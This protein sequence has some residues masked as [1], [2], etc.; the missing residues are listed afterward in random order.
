M[1]R[2]SLGKGCR[3]RLCSG[4]VQAAVRAVFKGELHVGPEISICHG[5][6]P[7]L[8]PQL[9]KPQPYGRVNGTACAWSSSCKTQL[10][11]LGQFLRCIQHFHRASA[12]PVTLGE[13]LQEARLCMPRDHWPC[14]LSALA[15]H[16]CGAIPSSCRCV[17]IGISV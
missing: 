11:V 4:A 6:I 5:C 12:T 15:V 8:L 17:S 9:P 2:V 7:S 1:K 13:D 16:A 3:K 10:Q 14:A